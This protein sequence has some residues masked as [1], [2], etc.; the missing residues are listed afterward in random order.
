M[1]DDIVKRLE[2]LAR[3]APCR[4]T[5]L[6]GVDN[7]VLDSWPVPVS[8]Q[9]RDVLRVFG[10]FELDVFPFVLTGYPEQEWDLPQ[11]CWV[12]TDDAAGG[13][14]WVDITPDGHW[15]PVLT[16]Y[17]KG[18]LYVQGLGPLDWITRLI[19]TAETLLDSDFDDDYAYLQAFGDNIHS[20]GPP[21]TSH[22]AALL[23]D[24]ADPALAEF[25]AE[26]PDNA[27]ICDLRG[28]PTGAYAPF[29]PYARCLFE[30]ATGGPIYAEVPLK[31]N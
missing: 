31:R 12:V 4:V 14:T 18:G 7:A 8:A 25:A 19:D 10:G 21:L 16:R 6:D 15:G 3:R 11:Q 28:A 26:L 30:R 1:I 20:A 5:I 9:M 13:V 29:E 2:G 24:S 22:P 17:R 27:E 23:R